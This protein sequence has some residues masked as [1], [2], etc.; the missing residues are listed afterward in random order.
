M[1]PRYQVAYVLCRET[2]LFSQI[3]RFINDSWVTLFTTNSPLTR[4][5][6]F[7]QNAGFTTSWETK[8][9]S[10]CDF[11]FTPNLAVHCQNLTCYFSWKLSGYV[12]LGETPV[13]YP[14]ISHLMLRD[15]QKYFFEA[16]YVYALFQRILQEHPQYRGFK[17][18]VNPNQWIAI[19]PDGVP[20]PEHHRK[21]VCVS[22]NA[23][24]LERLEQMTEDYKGFEKK[25]QADVR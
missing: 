9:I 22:W 14:R 20:I 8:G 19:Y 5:Q 16:P 13:T 7:F 2:E 1:P 10:G 11:V 17:M 18:D 23:F 15:I 24:I 3:I 6:A 12:L 4:A 21:P 25:Q